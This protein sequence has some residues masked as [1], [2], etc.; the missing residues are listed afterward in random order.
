M[1]GQYC[2]EGQGNLPVFFLAPADKGSVQ[3]TCNVPAGK[4]FLSR[5]TLPS[6]PSK[7]LM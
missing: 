1:N 3:R 5:L 4:A 7:S 2:G 6:A